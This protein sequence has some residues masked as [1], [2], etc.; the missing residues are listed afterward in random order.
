M[1]SKEPQNNWIFRNQE[2]LFELH[3]E[4]TNPHGAVSGSYRVLRGGSWYS[5][6]DYCTASSR[7]NNDATISIFN[8][9]LRL[10]RV[11]P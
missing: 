8:I 9:G 10:V 3:T 4:Q 6:A 7:S 5:F 1:K 2:R 11:S